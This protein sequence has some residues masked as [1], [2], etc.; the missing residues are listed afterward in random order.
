MSFCTAKHFFSLIHSDVNFVFLHSLKCLL[1]VYSAVDS[2]LEHGSIT[3]CPH[4][5]VGM[6]WGGV[7]WGGVG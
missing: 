2:V 6:G 5:G 3:H 1:I 7:W 4:S